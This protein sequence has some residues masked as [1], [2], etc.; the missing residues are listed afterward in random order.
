M[1]LHQPKPPKFYPVEYL[2]G[3]LPMGGFVN[4]TPIY[5]VIPSPTL[6]APEQ[7]IDNTSRH[8]INLANKLAFTVENVLT[9]DEA[10]AIVALTEQLGYRDEAPGI[11]TPPGMRMNQSV[12]WLADETFLANLY[13]RLRRHL[14]STLDTDPLADRFSQRINM[15][16][17]NQNDV[18]N[19][20]IDGDWPGYG[21]SADQKS[22]VQWPGMRSKLTMLLY[23]N[24][25]EEGVRG[26]VTYLYQNDGQRLSV[27]P[28]KGRALFFRHGHSPDSVLHEGAK[29]LSTTSKYV[30]RVNILYHGRF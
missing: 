24:G 12:H 10:D 17:Y 6:L 15:Y 26:G 29:V 3:S 13:H 20:H 16:K 7:W 4:N 30:A 23:L 28:K 19:R 22:M 18:F 5:A 25:P 21:L 9:D 14:P 27:T 8:T 11:Q 1:K 2:Q